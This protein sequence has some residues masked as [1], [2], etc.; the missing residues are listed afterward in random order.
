MWSRDFYRYRR[1]WSSMM[2]GITFLYCLE[3]YWIK[4]LIRGFFYSHGGLGVSFEQWWFKK[5]DLPRLEFS[6]NIISES[7]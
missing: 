5:F 6:L 4:I 1:P 2:M 3:F 7:Y